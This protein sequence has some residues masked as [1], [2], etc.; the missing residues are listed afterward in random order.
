MADK[1]QLVMSQGPQ[2]GQIF[3]LNH[4]ILT[5]GRDPGNDIV[6]VDPQTSRQH[7]R[8]MRRGGL[9]IL[10]DLGSTNGTFVNGVRL[11]GPHTLSNDDVIGIGDAVILTFRVSGIPSTE[12]VVGRPPAPGQTPSEPMA[13]APAPASSYTPPPAAA[14]RP[15]APPSHHTPSP[16]Y[17]PAPPPPEYAAAPYSAAEKR[18][19]AKWWIAGCAVLV[20]LAILAC[21]GVFVLDYL[22]LLPPIFYEPLRWLGFF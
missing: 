10:E 14:T 7:A 6:I 9:M 3:D 11:T 15:P 16:S 8:I 18:S 4:D 5:L 1:S 20:V 12:T 22:A 13:A 21:A 17:T 2:P 19:S